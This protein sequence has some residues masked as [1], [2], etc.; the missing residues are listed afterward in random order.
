[1]TPHPPPLH[2]VLNM[3]TQYTYSNQRPYIYMD[4]RRGL[5]VRLAWLEADCN[6]LGGGKTGYLK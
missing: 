4:K 2:S 5:P 3:Y 1:M 6:M